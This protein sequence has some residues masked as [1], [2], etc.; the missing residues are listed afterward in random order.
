M[1]DCAFVNCDPLTFEKAI[2][3]DMLIQ[4]MNQEINK[5][6]NKTWE[7]LIFQKEKNHRC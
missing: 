6:R 5:Y 4:A 3:E 7:L 1:N 2:E